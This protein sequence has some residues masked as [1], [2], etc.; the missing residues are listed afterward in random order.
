MRFDSLIATS[1]G[2]GIIIPIV[3]LAIAVPAGFVWAKKLKTGGASPSVESPTAAGTRLTSAALRDLASPPWRIVYEI[4][5]EKLDGIEHVIIGPAGVF[6]VQTSMDPLPAPRVEPASAHEIARVAILR[7]GLDDALRRCAMTSDQLVT[8]HWGVGSEP[9]GPAVE[10][11]P[12][13]VAVDGRAIPA[14]A[15]TLREQRLS[16]AQVDLAWQTVVT[17]IGRP[18]PLAT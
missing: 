9:H 4:A 15:A 18:D 2:P 14:W 11:S 17:A 1:I 3:L 8:F 13:A 5:E 12:G 16:A 7:G 10:V 6:A